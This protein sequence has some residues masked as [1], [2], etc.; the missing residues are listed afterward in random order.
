M[1]YKF[2]NTGFK[3]NTHVFL[4]LVSGSS[5]SFIIIHIMQQSVLI[6]ELGHKASGYMLYPL[7]KYGKLQK[8]V[9]FEL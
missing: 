8:S 5:T 1:A 7:Q 9:E 6:L 2:S 4:A 3:K